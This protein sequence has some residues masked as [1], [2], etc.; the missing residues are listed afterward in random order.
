MLAV[1]EDHC[2][3]AGKL[4]LT[5]AIP[6]Y[7]RE[8]VLLDTLAALLAL[9]PQAAEIL[10][11]D[12]TESHEAATEERLEELATSGV[13]RWLRLQQPS[14]PQAMNRGLLE[15]TQ[16][17]VLFVDDD[18]RPEP[19]LLTAHLE[20][21][22]QYP[23]VLVAGRV[24][25]PWQ[26]GVDFSVENDFHFATLKPAWINEF[27]GGNFSVE[28]EVTLAVG[29]FDEN[30]IR[31]AYRFEAEFAERFRRSGRRI[32]FEPRA[33]LHHLKAGGGGTR[34]FGSHLTTCKPDHAVGAYYFMLQSRE[35]G[36]QDML[37]RI[38]TSVA[39]RHHLKRPWWI[40]VTLVAELSGLALAIFLKLRGTRY[41]NAEK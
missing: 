39:T 36:I 8:T 11:L 2:V 12:Q 40:P 34:S 6:T 9:S 37:K 22:Q 28:R 21:H 32:Y 29:G 7:R 4:P 35:A 30:F 33:C 14:I 31:V 19:E 3:N 17:I 27:M 10:L 15:A 38:V 20:A 1:N 23:K 41:I 5:I 13:I 16:D 24:I 26:E 25:Q 18:V